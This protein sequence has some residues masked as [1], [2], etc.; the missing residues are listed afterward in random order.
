MLKN[1]NISIPP[2]EI[3][4]KYDYDSDFKIAISELFNRKNDSFNENERMAYGTEKLI[5]DNWA[6]YKKVYKLDKT[7]TNMLINTETKTIPVD[8]I[9]TIPF[10]TFYLK[11]DTDLILSALDGILAHIEF[12][13]NTV[14][15]LLLLYQKDD[16][17]NFLLDITDYDIVNNEIEL[18]AVE[19]ETIDLQD[20]NGIMDDEIM[21]Y[22]DKN[23][24]IIFTKIVMQFIMYISS[25]EPDIIENPITKK[26]YK[27]NKTIKNK[28]SEIQMW[29]VGV[30]YGKAIRLALEESK[31]YNNSIE[32]LKNES[33]EHKQRKSP[34]P[35]VRR[36]HWRR[37]RTGKG[38]TEV[39]L[40]WIPPIIVCGDKEIAVTIHNTT[41]D[42]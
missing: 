13:D 8:V 6:Q 35:H 40:I 17:E 15:V 25:K 1:N 36:A 19:S 31:K 30:R 41:I 29:D 12:I 9:K 21:E 5:L 10:S 18:K 26:T 27:P 28:F 16:Y 7:F 11:L 42:Q 24:S 14:L 33:K 34:R 38:R 39:T 22:Y 32:Y 2:L 23:N 37:A 20:T 4:R 3:L